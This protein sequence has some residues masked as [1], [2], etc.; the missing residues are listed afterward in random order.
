MGSTN[1]LVATLALAGVLVSGCAGTDATST[2]AT[3]QAPSEP[4]T[5]DN[6][7]TTEQTTAATTSS[8]AP[9]QEQE[10]LCTGGAG[11]PGIEV[12]STWG[13]GIDRE[14]E[15]HLETVDPRPDLSSSSTTPYN[16]TATS[17][18][19]G[20]LY[21]LTA[22]VTDISSLGIPEQHFP[23][24]TFDQLP[25]E[26]LVYL[27]DENGVF[28]SIQ[29]IDEVRANTVKGLEFLASRASNSD[30]EA[31]EQTAAVFNSLGDAELGQIFGERAMVMHAFDGML[32]NE[33]QEIQSPDVLPNSFGG[34]PF[35]AKTTITHLT[36]VDEDGCEVILISTTLDPEETTRIVSET[37]GEVFDVDSP[38]P[39]EIFDI[40]NTTVLQFDG[41]ANEVR[42]ITAQQVLTFQGE[43]KTE[44]V[45]IDVLQ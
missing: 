39:Q 20:T 41:G 5:A 25:R 4:A 33:G 35:P 15:I 22:G 26:H 16:L 32:L 14:L 21:E 36:G 17:N 6:S 44:S 34:E 19:Q 1:R 11:D 42:R 18:E 2:T 24:E 30:V 10:A 13:D 38:Q 29:N 45:V 37:I 27:V 31:Y 3:N 28:Q 12:P 43:T 23:S 7:T 8:A 40:Q 9:E